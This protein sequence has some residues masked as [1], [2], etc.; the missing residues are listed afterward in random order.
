MYWIGAFPGTNCDSDNIDKN[1]KNSN[2]SDINDDD[3]CVDRG[4]GK[5]RNGTHTN[6]NIQ[7]ETKR[8]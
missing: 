1:E 7:F 4:V 5:D 6:N 3:V 8:N 2:H